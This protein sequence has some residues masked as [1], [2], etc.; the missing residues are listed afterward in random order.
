M[1][2]RMPQ[3]A[4]LS[5][6]PPMTGFLKEVLSRR[7]VAREFL[8]NYLSKEVAG[9]MDADSFE[10]TKDSFISEADKIC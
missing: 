8:L 10:L 9:L 4:P 6:Q 2:Q 3:A 5:F 7:E 1:L